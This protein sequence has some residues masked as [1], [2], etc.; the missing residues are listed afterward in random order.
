MK[1]VKLSLLIVLFFGN[2]SFSASINSFIENV[3]PSMNAVSV[4]KYANIKFLF[5][6]DMN[7]ASINNSNIK[8]FGYQS[9]LLEVSISY[10]PLNRTLTI[11]PANDFKTGELISVTLTSGIQTSG[12]ISINPFTYTFTTKATGGYGTFTKTQVIDVRSIDFLLYG[13]GSNA[14]G[15]ADG[16]EDIDI[17]SSNYQK[18]NIYTNDGSANFTLHSSI[19]YGGQI[20]IADFN[21]DKFP[22][23]VINSISL[24]TLEYT[25]DTLRLY[26]NDGTGN[27]VFDNFFQGRCGQIADLNGDGY[28]DMAYYI[29]PTP[30]ISANSVV[31]LKNTNSI[32]TV[33]TALSYPVLTGEGRYKDLRIDDFNNDG[34]QD[35]MYMNDRTWVLNPGFFRNV[36]TFTYIKNNGNNNYFSVRFDS[37][38]SVIPKNFEYN[39]LAS[40]N[41][42]DMNNDGLVDIIYPDHK[43]INEGNAEFDKQNSF[44]FYFKSSSGDFNGDGFIDLIAPY[45]GLFSENQLTVYINNGSGSF[46]TQLTSNF[47]YF[48]NSIGDFDNDGD[49]DVATL[50][51]ISGNSIF[52]ISILLNNNCISTPVNLSGSENIPLNSLILYTASEGGGFWEIINTPPCN[53]SISGNNY[54]DSVYVNA[55]FIPG[56][57]ALY[58]NSADSCGT[59]T[60]RIAVNVDNPLP[61]ELISLSSAVSLRNVIL[62]WSTSSEENNSGFEIQRRNLNEWRRIGFLNGHGNSKSIKYYSFED[63]KLNSGK[64]KYRLKQL[65]FNGNFKYYD[66]QNEVLIGI[67]E[68]YYLSQNYPNP[69]N[70][71]TKIDFDIPNDGKVSLKVFDINGREIK[72]IINEF[73]T[74]GYYTVEINSFDLP[75]GIYF[76]RL[77]AEQFVSSKKII[78]LK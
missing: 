6:Q 61:A 24:N 64:Y 77:S 28:L 47:K 22:D 46:E 9:G 16:D 17:V 75:T 69:F 21:N 43:F 42:F 14:C 7:A 53:A 15:D 68:K 52:V 73:K 65:D 55:G 66:L 74:A 67:P 33:D 54:N 37:L 39:K 63:K 2:I 35:M 13:F 41:S 62:N 59:S 29:Y 30:S 31:I 45:N 32:F 70:P 38:F 26:L 1:V 49:L 44:Q 18:T 5:V 60:N 10:N 27:F 8:V 50:E 36:K 58:Y 34:R 72:T 40:F 76:C 78:L 12:A 4:F 20:A 48:G 11:D 71:T 51:S 23:I 57:F 19:N 3:T 25:N 56:R